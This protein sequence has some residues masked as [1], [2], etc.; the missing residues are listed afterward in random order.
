MKIKVRVHAG[1]SKE[2]IKNLGGEYE[3]WLK[4]R[5]IEGEA[6]EELLKILKKYFGKRVSISS[7]LSSRNKII[8]VEDEI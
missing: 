2:E 1:S 8:E 7:G 6:N 5:A 3:V 4:K